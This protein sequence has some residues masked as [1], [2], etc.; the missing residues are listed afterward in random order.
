MLLLPHPPFTEPLHAWL[1][2]VLATI[3]TRAGYAEHTAHPRP[4]VAH[5]L[6]VAPRQ[7]TKVPLASQQTSQPSMKKERSKERKIERKKE[8]KNY[9]SSKKLLTSIKEKGPLGKKSPF[10]RKE[11][12]GQ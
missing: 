12:G 4:L 7:C 9:T 10:A 8:K 11:K 3:S 6:V 1:W 5:I 2:P